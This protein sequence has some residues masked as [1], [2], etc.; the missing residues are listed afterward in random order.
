MPTGE[1]D[2]RVLEGDDMIR[3]VEKQVEQVFKDYQDLLGDMQGIDDRECL[4]K[5]LNERNALY[6]ISHTFTS[7][8]DKILNS[9]EHVVNLIEN[10]A[11]FRG[12]EYPRWK[13]ILWGA[14]ALIL[15]VRCWKFWFHGWQQI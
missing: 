11:S 15:C 13:S 9:L 12:I 7:R 1:N 4:F 5:Y 8:V 6:I 10:S 3:T 2:L 14:T